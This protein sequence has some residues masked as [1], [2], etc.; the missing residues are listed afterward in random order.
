[1][2][3]QTRR[4]FL[5]ITAALAACGVTSTWAKTAPPRPIGIQ[6]YMLGSSLQ[7]LEPTLA[8]VREI[9]FT[10]IELP[11]LLDRSA[12]DLAALIKRSKLEA[13]SLHAMPSGADSAANLTTGLDT[14]IE[15]A[16]VLGC[17]HVVCAMPLLPA[18]VLKQQA[19]V[20][21]FRAAL[22]RLRLEDWKRNADFLNATGKKLAAAGLTFA[23]HNHNM[24]FV[25]FKNENAYDYTL[26]TTDP[27]LVKMQMDC[28]WM[29]AG[30]RDPVHYLSR[31]K[32]RYVSLH[33]KDLAPG[34][35]DILRM[36]PAD[37]GAGIIDWTRVLPAAI[38][39]GVQYFFVEQEPP[40]TR[41]PLDSAR[42]AYNMLR[43][44]PAFAAPTPTK[45]R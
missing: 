19:D 26:R 11:G 7:A 9:G 38:D 36:T 13:L 44:L 22:A 23:Y 4:E 18:A 15:A 30:K 6:L 37:V 2:T 28:A 43:T 32:D 17:K 27:A 35:N 10:Q 3:M 20:K 24:E 12:E 34:A 14:L 16:H 21:K 41:T 1:M 5:K 29:V 31:H 33:V 42:V 40:F 39:A 8:A 25:E 45:G